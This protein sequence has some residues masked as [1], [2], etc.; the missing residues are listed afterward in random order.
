MTKIMPVHLAQK[1]C[2][3]GWKYHP[4][5]WILGVYNSTKM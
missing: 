3:E 4:K 2:D 5:P 1:S